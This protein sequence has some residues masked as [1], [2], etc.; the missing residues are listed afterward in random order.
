MRLR[1]FIQVMVGQFVY[2][3][4]RFLMLDWAAHPSILVFFSLVVVGRPLDLRT[5][6]RVVIS[7]GYALCQLNEGGLVVF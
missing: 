3:V 7:V 6:S 2:G 4:L 5:R 1:S